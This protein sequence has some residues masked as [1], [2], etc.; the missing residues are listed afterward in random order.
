MDFPFGIHEFL[1]NLTVYHYIFFALGFIASILLF[2]LG[3]VFR[4][5]HGA[6]LFFYLL[7]F[8]GLLVAPIIGAYY[9]EEYL[10]AS[11]LK[12]ID[13]LRLTFTKA[14]VL[15]ADIQNDGNS[16]IGTTYISL[17]MVKKDKNS[18]LQFINTLKP[19]YTQKY[20]YKLPMQKG[21]SAH[22]R[23]VIDTTKLPNPSNYFIFYQ[24]KS[25]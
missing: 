12:N 2:L 1:N 25:F 20:V 8:I 18:I 3:I 17:Q 15:N 24:I 22:I 7:S 14:I 5:R 11:S 23:A 19:A 16:N 21:E 9:T 6:A 10:R 4:K 13:I